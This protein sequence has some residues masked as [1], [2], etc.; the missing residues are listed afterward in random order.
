MIV[1]LAEIELVRAFAQDIGADG[2]LR[3]AMPGGPGF[4]SVEERS[5]STEAAVAVAD[6]ESVEFGARAD[7]N[8][9]V[10]ADMRPADN[11]SVGRFGDKQDVLRTAFQLAKAF[12]DFG[13]CGGIAELAREL[14][15]TRSVGRAGAANF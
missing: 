12:G 11:A 7:F 10:H 9:M 5:T 14:G 6:D 13:G 8:E 4:D 15:E 3:T 2:Q 1:A